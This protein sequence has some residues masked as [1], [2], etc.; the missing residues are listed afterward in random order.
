MG[1]QHQPDPDRYQE[2]DRVI[3]QEIRQGRKFSIASAIGKEGGDFLKGESPVPKLLQVKNELL[4][5][6]RQN[7]HDPSGA[8]QATLQELIR[9]DDVICSRYFEAPLSALVE[10]LHPLTV[11]ET[12]LQDF[13][14]R[15][16]MRWGQIYDERPHF[17]RPGHPPHPEDEY[18]YESVRT[19]LSE[20]ITVAE[21]QQ[22]S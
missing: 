10:L 21:L 14:R 5:F 19:Q 8:L 20:L 13:V 16:D 15:V 12:L 22:S 4:V 3:E 18:T 1:I 9:A 7:L 17:E 2:R 11:Q 6:V